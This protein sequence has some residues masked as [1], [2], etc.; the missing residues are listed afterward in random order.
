MIY[1]QRI[2][3]QLAHLDAHNYPNKYEENAHIR[4]GQWILDESN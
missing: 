2:E 4:E 3:G 1:V